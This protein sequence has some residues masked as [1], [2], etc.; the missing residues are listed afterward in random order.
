M[1]LPQLQTGNIL[2]III[3]AFLTFAHLTALNPR[4]VTLAIL[5]LAIALP[6][7]ASL[8]S[9]AGGNEKGVP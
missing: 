9:F 2:H 7:V 4:A 6:A 3:L 5:F 1:H 8:E